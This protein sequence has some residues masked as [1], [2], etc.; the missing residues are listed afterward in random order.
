MLLITHGRAQLD[1]IITCTN[2]FIA[3]K[4]DEMTCG[5]HKPTHFVVLRFDATLP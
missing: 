5:Q 3:I 4:I 2:L 1:K